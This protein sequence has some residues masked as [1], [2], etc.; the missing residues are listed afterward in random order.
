MV[1]PAVSTEKLTELFLQLASLSM[2]GLI[3]TRA[4]HEC[5][6]LPGQRCSYFVIL[7][8]QPEQRSL[9]SVLRGTLE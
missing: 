1:S 4:D 2:Q 5:I 6:N 3:C 9:L 8:L 7:V